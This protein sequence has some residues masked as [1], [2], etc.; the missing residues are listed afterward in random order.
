MSGVNRT[1]FITRRTFATMAAAA[2]L[3][4]TGP[5]SG[6]HALTAQEQHVSTLTSDVMALARSGQRGSALQSS[7]SR[8]LNRHSNI[9]SVARFALG[10]YRGKLPAA[11]KKEYYDLVQKYVAALFA[12]YVDDFIGTSVEIEK[13]HASGKFVI[14][15]SRIRSAGT[16]LR[17]RVYSKGSKHRITDVNFRGIWLSI[18]MRDQ[19]V[20]VLKNNNGDFAALLQY[21]RTNS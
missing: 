15:D 8:M 3:T 19:F 4:L 17:W 5:M 20:S 13:S 16:K 1:S 7:V 18:R 12:E 11:R 10:P 6:A 9:S 14:V 2:A 21:L